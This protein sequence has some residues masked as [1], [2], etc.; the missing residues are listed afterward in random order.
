MSSSLSH[1]PAT[2]ETISYFL[3]PNAR[4][5]DVFCSLYGDRPFTSTLS[6]ADTVEKAKRLNPQDR[7]RNVLLSYMIARP[8]EDS[9]GNS[10]RTIESTQFCHPEVSAETFT[11]LVQCCQPKPEFVEIENVRDCWN[12]V[13][14]GNLSPFNLGALSKKG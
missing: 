10:Y 11:N 7:L 12:R 13:F 1:I 8:R 14:P 4:P 9:N 3:P 2:S 5:E 6:F